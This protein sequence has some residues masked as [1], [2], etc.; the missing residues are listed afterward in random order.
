MEKH[1]AT[2]IRTFSVI[3]C[4]ADRQSECT[5][6]LTALIYH[7]QHEWAVRTVL[8]FPQFSNTF[9]IFAPLHVDDRL[10]VSSS[11]TTFNKL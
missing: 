10:N 3:S 4:T 8:I 1:D 7:Q 9:E 6:V 5:K 2:D 11:S